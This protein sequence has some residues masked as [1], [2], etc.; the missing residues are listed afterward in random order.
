MTTILTKVEF[1]WGA[2]LTALPATWTWTDESA[3]ALGDVKLSYGRRDET[4]QTQPTAASFRLAN[5]N[6]RFS[7]RHPSSALYPNVKL[8]TPVR[9]SINPGTGY[10]QRVIL[11]VTGIDPVFPAGN[12]D[13]AEVQVTAAGILQRLGQGNAPA[14]SAQY[15]ANVQS[16]PTAYWP[17][18][19]GA[20]AV[21]A[22]SPVPG[23]T[24]M[25]V[26][27][28]TVVAFA[29]SAG[30]VGS[31]NVPTFSRG[32]LG[33]TLVGAVPTGG[34]PT[35]WRVDFSFRCNVFDAGVFNAMV[36]WQTLG[37]IKTWEIDAAQ[38]ADG[39]LFLQYITAAGVAGGPFLS[40]VRVDD[41][42]WHYVS[43]NATQSGGNI[44]FGV[45]LDG[46]VV[47]S[48]SVAATIG[49]VSLA[50]INP[51]Q[52]G[53]ES[54]PAVAHLGVW[55][56]FASAV[57]LRAAFLGNAGETAGARITRIAADEGIPAAVSSTTETARMGPQGIATPLAIFRDCET[58]DGGLLV[59]GGLNGGITYTAAQDRMSLPATMALDCKRQQ[60]KL[61]FA[62][63]E[64]DQ[65]KRNRWTIARLGGAPLTFTD[66]EHVARNNGLIYADGTSLNLLSDVQRRDEAGW[67]VNLGTVEEMRVPDL[68]LQLI[69]RPELWTPWL[70]MA[71]GKRMTAANLPAQYPPGT[72]DMA[73]EGATETWSSDSWRITANTAPYAPWRVAV[74]AAD[75]GDVG[76]FVGRFNPTDAALNSGITATATSISVK[77]N[78]GPLWTTAADDFPFDIAID[79]EQIRV[80]N[81]TGASSPQTF[82]VT[83]AIN[84]V[85]MSHLVNAAVTLWAPPIFAK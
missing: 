84:S 37:T 61:P 62:P 77:T 66:D 40:N 30:P 67:R 6:S 15:R 45:T 80:T 35:S 83:R 5:T 17:L 58:V 25:Y 64:D 85:T 70:A 11:Y 41:T 32:G 51:T 46:A 22:E 59:D 56:P 74:F 34:S 81:I 49:A 65:R 21:Q 26:L 33:G 16:N 9:I 69:D 23:V 44:N 60:V 72:L 54:A 31:A 13:V 27:P 63:K 8:Q 48:S 18:E 75:S 78:S 4:S 12:S 79:G 39:G 52:I 82:T 14:K 2:D 7:A 53:D 50:T 55:A 19:D 3:Y 42:L 57:D 73:L 47:I 76:E 36:Q 29:T 24:P 1:A 20:D 28:G 43:I 38:L 10:T 68:T 71:P